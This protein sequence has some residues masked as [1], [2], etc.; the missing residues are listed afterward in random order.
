MSIDVEAARAAGSLTILDAQETLAKLMVGPMPDP[1]LFRRVVGGVIEW[2]TTQGRREAKT[3]AY[4]EMV[5]LL[6][7]GG[8]RQAALRLEEMWNELQSVYPFDL[9]CAYSMASFYRVPD[10]GALCEICD[11][12]SHVLGGAGPGAGSA[13]PTGAGPRNPGDQISALLAEIAHRKEVEQA[14]RDCVRDLR[15][16]EANERARAERS[17]ELQE[18]HKRLADQLG[19]TVH[20]N[21][22][23]TGVLAHD[24]RTP[25]AAI[26]TGARLIEKRGSAAAID[27]RTEKSLSR[28]IAS[29]ER[30]ARMIEQLLDFTR[31]RTGGGIA[32][33]PGS[34]DLLSL[35]EQVVGE[36]EGAYPNSS[37][38]VVHRGDMGGT[39][40]GDRLSQVF[41]NLIANA[42]QH[43]VPGA[44]I[45]V[46]VDGSAADS[47][48]VE[49]HNMGAIPPHV[50]P[51]LFDPLKGGQRRRDHS[52]G[53]GLGLFITK[54]IA[55]AHGGDVEVSSSEAAGTTFTLSLPR[56]ADRAGARMDRSGTAETR[57]D[58]WMSAKPLAAAESKERLAHLVE[59]LF[60]VSRIATCRFVLEIEELDLVESVTRVVDGLRPAAEGARC[61]LSIDA[62][63]SVV[64]AWDRLRLEQ[65]VTNLVSSAL[66]YGAGRPVRISVRQDAGE[67]TLEV[68]AHGPGIPEA[69]LGRIPGRSAQ[70]SMS[71]RDC[72]GVGLGLY[73]TQAVV[74]A[75]GGSVA[76][77]NPEGGGTR[78]RIRLPLQA[79]VAPSDP[80]RPPETVN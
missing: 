71:A 39:W 19:D 38:E 64:G 55:V 24:L 33:E 58:P 45:R 37:V 32:L 77:E 23:F 26:I 6:W 21:E 60:D 2:T 7:Q 50:V 61:E 66:K 76:A 9:L 53:L 10:A 79:V 14:L 40:D 62:Q 52:Q 13:A 12:H 44:G 22:L 78:F 51:R 34:A 1:D 15:R 41:S 70:S 17:I 63:G 68:S 75:H 29:S 49:V 31:L 57:T 48:R 18:A 46:L 56:Y 80:T 3:R 73:L 74:N 27:E 8:N 59:S 5:D 16:S 11:T 30:M 28:V 4:G 25:L 43:G 36:M 47:V 72:E 69:A 20:M 42:L 65:A 54:R 67:V 35:V